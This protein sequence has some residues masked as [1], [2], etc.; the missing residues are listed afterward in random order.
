MKSIALMIHDI[1]GLNAAE[2]PCVKQFFD[3]FLP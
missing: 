2:T 1:D 3:C